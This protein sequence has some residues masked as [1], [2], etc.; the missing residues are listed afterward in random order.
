MKSSTKSISLAAKYRPQDFASVVGQETITSILSKTAFEQKVAPAYLLSGTRGVGKTTIARIF[1]KALN[2]EKLDTRTNGEPCNV[3]QTCQ[4][5]TQG[6]FVDVMEIDGASN[7]GVDDAKRIRE[8]VQYPP[9][10]G[11]FKIIIIDEAHMLTR[12]AFNALLK[13]LEEPP[14]YTS[15]ILA[16]TEAH[17]FPITIVSRC[18]HFVFKQVPPLVLEKHLKH[19]LT[20]ED[21]QYEEEAVS[22]LVR[23]AS[24]SVR[25]A[26]SLLGQA[27]VLA[28]NPLTSETT[29]SILGLAGKDILAQILEAIHENNSLQIAHAVDNMMQQGIDIVY[30]MRELSQIWR[31]LHLIKEYKEQSYALL[32]L[33]Q[34]E[35]N[36]YTKYAQIFSLAFIHSAWQITLEAQRRISLSLEPAVALELFL[37]NL[38]LLPKLLPLNELQA[39][40][41][42]KRTE[43]KANNNS[44]VLQEEEKKK[45]EPENI[46]LYTEINTSEGAIS[47]PQKAN[48]LTHDEIRR[49]GKEESSPKDFQEA[50]QEVSQE[51]F[52]PTAEPKKHDKIIPIVSDDL[53]SEVKE[54]TI[55]KDSLEEERTST[56]HEKHNIH[57]EKVSESNKFFIIAEQNNAEQVTDIAQ[58]SMHENFDSEQKQEEKGLSL[59]F[60]DYQAFLD[61]LS[62]NTHTAHDSTALLNNLKVSE[63]KFSF[64]KEKQNHTLH[65]KAPSAICAKDLKSAQMH[66]QLTKHLQDFNK[67]LDLA[68]LNIEISTKLPPKNTADLLEELDKKDFVQ[69]VK[70]IFNAH[71]IHCESHKID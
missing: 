44:S 7:R 4:K 17:K 47:K 41:Q 33:S 37:I 19:V 56:F 28:Q 58:T 54:I 45:T 24:G 67:D 12:E 42:P 26:M 43:V 11:R 52:L 8:I 3:C 49:E 64:D 40:I 5:I 59:D 65:L 66:K 69:E 68:K 1:A 60:L 36:L 55:T 70:K 10:E 22:L 61:F 15:F 51:D 63:G 18:Q 14:S 29:R 27:L 23:R 25:D 50:L 38:A 34:D 39:D 35:I 30:F 62:H 48:I 16:T 6:A 21:W 31:S 71:I 2:C 20:S 46:S 53:D 13:T 57:E 9:L 32:S